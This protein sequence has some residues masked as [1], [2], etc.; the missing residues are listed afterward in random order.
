MSLP[1]FIITT[2]T[3]KFS[4]ISYLCSRHDVEL[5][6]L[7]YAYPE[8]QDNNMHNLLVRSHELLLEEAYFPEKDEVFF[9]IEQTSVFLNSFPQ[10]GPGCFFKDW[11]RSVGKSELK[12]LVHRDPR[13]TIESGMA[14][15]IPDH[16]P[17]IFINRKRGT[18]S[19]EG[20]ILP[21]NKDYP[22]LS[23]EDFNLYFV[24]TKASRVYNAM[25]LEETLKYDF[26]KPNVDK[27]CRRIQEYF[28]ILSKNLTL[29]DIVA[30]ARSFKQSKHRA[31]QKRLV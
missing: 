21:E 28:S 1:L 20:Y 9:I 2:S 31:K 17:L 25:P 8:V 6:R 26:R 22:W 19:F 27:V 7:P 23:S 12:S 11:W 24:P 13:A 18:V 29:Q 3:V 5:I 16:S 15:N 14:L 30:I 10:K 4:H